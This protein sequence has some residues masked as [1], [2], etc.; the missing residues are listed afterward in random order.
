MNP[1]PGKPMYRMPIT[2]GPSLGPRQGPDG[3]PFVAELDHDIRTASVTVETDGDALRELLPPGL[4]LAA[5]NFTVVICEITNIDWLAGRGYNL[6]NVNWPVTYRA[7]DGT[8]IDGDFVSVLW[9]NMADPIMTGREEM[10][11]P[12]LFADIPDISVADDHS[13]TASASWDGFTFLEMNLSDLQAVEPVPQ[14]VPRATFVYKYFPMA[15]HWGESDVSYLSLTPA[16]A[17]NMRILHHSS[18][19]GQ[20]RFNQAT[21]KEL[22]TLVTIVNGLA[23]LPV[24]RTISAGLTATVG[25]VNFRKQKRLL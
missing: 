14:A 10:G 20:V 15:E 7:A 2:F 11:Y 22:P 8:T 23:Q 1:N 4:E 17:N 6:V 24:G 21:W 12:K 5:P 18:A 9:E 25:G 19:N 3:M 16:E 13:A